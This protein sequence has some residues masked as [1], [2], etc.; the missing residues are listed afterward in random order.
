MDVVEKH[1]VNTELKHKYSE[2]K[3]CTWAEIENA[4]KKEIQDKNY[5]KQAENGPSRRHI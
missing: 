3:D 1:P 5:M 4:S 2:T